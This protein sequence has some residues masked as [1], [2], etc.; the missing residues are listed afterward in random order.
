MGNTFNKMDAIIFTLI[1]YL[2]VFA[3]KNEKK[4]K[5][6]KVALLSNTYCPANYFGRQTSNQGHLSL[7]EL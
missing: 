5:G 4:N 2:I 3:K 7:P 6:V 1:A